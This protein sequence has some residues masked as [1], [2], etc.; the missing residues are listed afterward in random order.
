M[1]ILYA[2]P[3]LVSAATAYFLCL[4]SPFARRHAVVVPVGIL[5][6]GFG[7]LFAFVVEVLVTRKFGRK[8]PATWADLLVSVLGGLLV[9]LVCSIIYRQ[10]VSTLATWTIQCGLV[11][12]SL[13][14]SVTLIAVHSGLV[15][16]YGPNVLKRFTTETDCVLLAA[17]AWLSTWLV[18][19][20]EL[21]RPLPLRI[22]HGDKLIQHS[23]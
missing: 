6:F 7:S 21:F 1:Q 11:A 13:C 19:R 9:S 3:F 14:S 2:A 22:E 4:L 10:V 5:S 12:A 15:Q 17:T 16:T 8:T 20:A 23:S 18:R